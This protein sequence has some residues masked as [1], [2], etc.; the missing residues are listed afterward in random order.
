MKYFRVWRTKSV[1]MRQ[2][3]EITPLFPLKV[4]IKINCCNESVKYE[5]FIFFLCIN[6]FIFIGHF[7]FSVLHL[8][9]PQR[10]GP[11]SFALHA[12][13]CLK[14]RAFMCRR[15]VSVLSKSNNAP[16]NCSADFLVQIH[17][18]WHYRLSSDFLCEGVSR[19][20][21]EGSAK[22]NDAC[23]FRKFCSLC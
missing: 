1:K 9:L 17:Y 18:V 8:T 4:N 12:L 6:Y 19:C 15:N 21:P 7:W 3:K 10:L 20:A 23:L 16:S 22:K 2:K 13:G 11:D 5:M 14:Q